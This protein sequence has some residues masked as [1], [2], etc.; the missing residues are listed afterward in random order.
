MTFIIYS[1]K[2]NL[3]GTWRERQTVT[4]PKIR[5]NTYAVNFITGEVIAEQ[6]L[7]VFCVMSLWARCFYMLRYNEYF[8]RLT[9]IVT[10]LIPDI[11]G[12]FLF[13]LIEIFFFAMVAEQAFRRLD[14][15]NTIQRSFATLFYASLGF[16]RFELF[17]QDT[18]FGE[19]FGLTFKLIFLAVNIGL[20]MSLFVSM[21][22]TLYGEYVRKETVY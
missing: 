5:A 13:Y 7:L 2:I 4:V 17:E 9:G 8:G 15:F 16:F 6:Y 10:R 18:T 11:L 19:Y 1:Y 14:E 21:L 3:A 12:F 20:F 22:T